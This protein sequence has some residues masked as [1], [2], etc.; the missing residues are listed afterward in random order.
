MIRF[1][2]FTP[3]AQAVMTRAYEVVRR[4]SHTLMD[5]EHVLLAL[6]EQRDDTLTQLFKQM[7]ADVPRLRGAVKVELESAPRTVKYSA[8]GQVFVAVRVRQLL[9]FAQKEAD[10]L[11]DEHVSTEHL[12][13]AM[14]SEWNTPTARL[15]SEQ[16]ISHDAAVQTVRVLRKGD[17]D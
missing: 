5:T 2:G 4:Y 7:K 15:L 10:R 16:G 1:D 9:D 14:C 6:L 12:L 8:E 13:L 3:Q 11:Y 17:A